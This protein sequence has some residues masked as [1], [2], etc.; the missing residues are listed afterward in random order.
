MLDVGC[1]TGVLTRMAA[2]AVNP[3]GEA[4]GI[5]PAPKMIE[6]A[7]RNAARTNNAAKFRLGVIE[8]LPFEDD[9]FD[10]VLATL[11]LHHLPPDLKWQ[12]LREV[13][14]V[15]K[16]G[17]R[18]LIVD[19]DRPANLLWWL[20]FWPALLHPRTRAHITGRFVATLI[21]A[22]FDP[23]DKAR[24]WKAILGV[25]IAWKSDSRPHDRC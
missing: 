19:F 25:W 14:R 20:I 1:G 24:N 4:V 15:L 13:Y 10:V 11:M 17:G 23:V 3:Q 9:S 16:P 18:L 2:D 22:G 21:Q 5:D 12:G 8:A 6:V 7:R